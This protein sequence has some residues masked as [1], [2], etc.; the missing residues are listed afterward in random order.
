MLQ[1][2]VMMLDA[3][4]TILKL[5]SMQQ[6]AG[7]LS[8]SDPNEVQWVN[9]RNAKSTWRA[10]YAE[11]LTASSNFW[12]WYQ[13]LWQGMIFKVVMEDLLFRCTLLLFHVTYH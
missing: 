9:R 11:R 4:Q 6:L 3:L 12:N 5:T 8:W 13:A 1:I 2:K 7:L 10:N